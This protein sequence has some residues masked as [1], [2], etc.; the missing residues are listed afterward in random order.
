MTR[1]RSGAEIGNRAWV[2]SRILPQMKPG[3]KRVHKHVQI[4]YP[5]KSLAMELASFVYYKDLHD[6]ICFLS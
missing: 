5:E 2:T 6:F 1:V 4:K 3:C